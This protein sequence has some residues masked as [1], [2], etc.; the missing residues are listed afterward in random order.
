MKLKPDL[1]EAKHWIYP[2]NRPKRDYQFNIVKRCLFDNTIVALP[3]GLGK[4]FIA[5][6]VMLNFYR[7]FPEGKVVFVAPTKPLVAQ[8]I[9]AS[10]KT[11]GIP[12]SDA[13][14]L[15]GNNPKAMRER[16]WREKRVFY[17]TP[18]TL[19]NDLTKGTC[20]VTDIVLLVVDEAHRAT[21]DFAYNQVVRYMMAKNPH[22][23]LL[24]LTA[25]PGSTPEAVQNLID[26]LHISN[27]E[28]RDENSIDLR[29]YL[30]EKRIEQHIIATDT[31]IRKVRD[32]LAKLIVEVL[33][34]I[35]S[36]M[37]GTREPCRINPFTPQALQRELKSHQNYARV[38]LMHLAKLT[39][40]MGYLL[41]GTIGMCYSSIK[42]IEQ[43]VDDPKKKGKK[44]ASNPLFKEVARALEDQRRPKSDPEHPGGFSMHPKMEKMK[45][46]IINH[47]AQEM[48]ESGLGAGDVEE[49]ARV[50]TRVM[51]FVTFR[52]AVE[53]IVDALNFER[54]LIRP[55]KFVGQGV[56]KKGGKGMAQKEQLAVIERFKAGEFNVLVATSIGEE[57]LDIGEVDLIVCYDAQKTPIRMLQRLGRTGR[58]R[59]G[60]VHVLLAEGREELNL[61]KAKDA[62]KQV[63]QSI[64]RGEA[65]ELYADVDRMLP[66]HIKPECLEQIMEIEEYSTKAGKRLVFEIEFSGGSHCQYV[67]DFGF[68]A[69]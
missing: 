47:F 12:G 31:S 57:G 5:G 45:S 11:C 48:E 55:T 6:V 16:A 15:T 46:I 34:P 52:E 24:A 10:H 42:E 21:G 56:D 54:P 69:V 3:T 8:Q 64:V 36:I 65:L 4:T 13:V 26:G 43:D 25:T 19:V 35:E 29:Q 27:I 66:D 30:H 2:L 62:Y 33:K 61:E 17:M 22:F 23:R 20:D 1:L 63:Q 60:V 7:W 9:E 53:E 39:R 37:R 51:V 40:V 44:L 41:E 32:P 49:S 67:D 68:V 50:E 14:E 38:P 28:I 59:A 18:Q 58:K